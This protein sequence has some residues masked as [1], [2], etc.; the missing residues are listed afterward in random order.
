M[1]R[2]IALIIE[3]QTR[4]AD[5]MPAHL[6]YKSPKS[7]WINAVINFMEV[8]DFSR[9]DIFFLSLVNRCMYRYDETVRPYPKREYHP[10]RKEC[11]SF[12]K[13]VLDFLQSFQE[14]LFVE[15]HMSLT[16]ANELRWLF[17][18]HGIE[19]KFYGEGQSLAGKPV[20]YQRLIEE[21]K[22]L[23][24]VQDIKRE[25]WE[26]AAGIM[27]RSPAEAQWILDEFGHKSYMFP[28]QVET[29]LEDLKHVMKKHHVRRKDEQKA[30]DDFIEAI[31]QED[32]AIEFQ[33]FCQDI[34]LLHKLCAKRE[35]YEALKREF[36]R[37]MSRFERY[38]I[39]REY[40]L[41]FENKISA[42]LLKLQI[43]LL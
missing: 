33:E 19:H 14:P 11:A 9:E 21:E 31:D 15:L 30:F 1:K 36:G 2:R 35:E 8:R 43:N 37:T 7:R 24:K 17:H 32:R 34:N 39:K 28:P 38:L 29:I 4:K 18:E 5:P 42:T 10:R 20:Y 26:L 16:L 3:S 41:E 22:T 13:E 27:T 6:F 25:K 40:A 23:R 12:A